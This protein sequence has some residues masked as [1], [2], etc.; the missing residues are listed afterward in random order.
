MYDILYIIHSSKLD[1]FAKTNIIK[2]FIKD[3]YSILSNTIIAN[4]SDIFINDIV[5]LINKHDLQIYKKG[6][7]LL[8]KDKQLYILINNIYIINIDYNDFIIFKKFNSY[9]HNQYSY[10]LQQLS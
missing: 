2:Q 8:T 9:K 3:R 1:K 6:K 5:I 4:Y 7:I 10:L